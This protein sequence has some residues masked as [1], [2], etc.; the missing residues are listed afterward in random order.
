MGLVTEVAFENASCTY[1]VEE[2]SRES[3][4]DPG[5]YSHCFSVHRI[6]NC[7]FSVQHRVDSLSARTLHRTDGTLMPL[8]QRSD[9]T[10]HV[11]TS[12]LFVASSAFDLLS[13]WGTWSCERSRIDDRMFWHAAMARGYHH[14]FTGAFTTRYEA[15]HVGFYRAIGET[16]P[17]RTSRH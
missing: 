13:L 1:S 4:V 2:S 17:K 12:C 7:V 10:E 6:L 5:V 8:L 15:S 11:D 16:P 9:N 3:H 14:S